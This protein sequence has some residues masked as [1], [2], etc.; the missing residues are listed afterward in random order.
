MAV[1]LV[2]GSVALFLNRGT[3]SPGA[4]LPAQLA[5]TLSALPAS[6]RRAA[7]HVVDLTITEPG[8]VTN[9]AALVLPHDLAVTT[10]V[11]PVTAHITGSSATKV[12]FP[13]TLISHD[14]VMGFSIVRLSVPIAAPRLDPMPASTAVVAIAPVVTGP[15]RPPEYFWAATTLGDPTNSA[16]GVVRY[17]ATT[18][19]SSLSSYVDA[20]AVDANGDVVA[21]LSARRRWYAATFVAQVASVQA[22]GRGCHAVLGITGTTEQ[23]GGVLVQRIVPYGA[24]WRAQ[25]KVG[26]VITAW[27]GTA[28]ET[29]TQLASTL[30]LTSAYTSSKLTYAQGTHV[31]HTTAYF[32]C[33]S[34]LVK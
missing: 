33:P 21:V 22:N 30:Y 31:H 23:G 27:N 1:L 18:N 29:W 2:L 26:D 16:Q 25:L 5:T 32:D 11:I 10:T 14:D 17:L 19:E 8:H 34:K 3:S 4:D 9:V 13:V 12:N 15:T 20:I 28:L 7:A 6:S 24:A